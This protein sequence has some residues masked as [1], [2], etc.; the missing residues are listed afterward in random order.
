MN[1]ELDN[2]EKFEDDLILCLVSGMNEE[3]EGIREIAQKYLENFGERRKI[4]FDKY[5]K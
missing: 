3:K 4:L 5:N 2:L 1:F